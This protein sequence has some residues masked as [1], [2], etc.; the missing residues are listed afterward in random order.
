M[1]SGWVQG[2]LVALM[3]Y[4]IGGIPFSFL[5]VRLVSGLDLRQRGSGN[6]GATNALRVGGK[7]AGLATLLLDV[8]KGLAAVWLARVLE[9]EAAFIGTA[10]VAVVAGHVLSVYLRF[11]GGKGVAAAAG[12]MIALA[13]L[14]ML[15]CLAAFSAIVAVTRYV[16]IG[17]VVSALLFAP[18][19]FLVGKLGWTA[20]PPQWLLVSGAMIALIITVRH[21]D[22]LARLR[23][24]TEVKLGYADPEEK[25]QET[26]RDRSTT[27]GTR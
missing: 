5:I 20:P 24:G 21:A 4:L 19:A 9:V 7:M 26:G 17:S 11:R 18:V 12:A 3:A 10:A 27:G 1:D 22:N 25:E 16:A 13:P 6:P 2:L 15:F 23:A 14:P 8:G